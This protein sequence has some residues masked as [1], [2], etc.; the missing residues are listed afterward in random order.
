[1]RGLIWIVGLFLAA[2]GLA[3]LAAQNEGYVLLVMPPWRAE[4]SLNL[5][6]LVS[7]FGFIAS[8]LVIRAA[9]H[10]Y[11]LPSTVAAYRAR[12]KREKAQLALNTATA[13][14]FEGQYRQAL[15]NAKHAHEEGDAPALA[16]L[17]AAR[18]AYGLRDD[19]KV[20]HW[21]AEAADS[22]PSLAAARGMTELEFLCDSRQFGA[23][24]RVWETLPEDAR[25]QVKALRLA[26]RIYRAL[27]Q[28]QDMLKT[29]RLLE[30]QDAIAPEAALPFKAQA[31]GQMLAELASNAKDDGNTRTLVDY[32]G[33]IPKEERR[34]ARIA[35]AGVEAYLT[36]GD[37]TGARKLIEAQVDVE[38]SS[39]LAML[40]AECG[41]EESKIVRDRLALGEKWLK[42]HP[43][44]ARLLLTLGRLCQ[45]L[46]LWGKAR[47]YFEASLSVETTMAA[48]LALAA[49]L[50]QLEEAESAN[51]AYRK[52]VQLCPGAVALDKAK[53]RG[54]SE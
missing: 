1:M 2:S 6:L 9:V 35:L 11:R 8:Y 17:V 45:N 44:D 42:A 13:E 19:E 36:A 3:Y 7:L 30:R 20:Q 28:W 10:L 38:W 48:Q 33:S 15:K 46:Q 25:R 21:L 41:A 37:T 31:H 22:G 53:P 26:L 34:N 24:L 51:T 29:V 32:W 4:V 40:Y 23:A 12:R 16:A 39:E 43:K 52:A 49:L 18:A 47:S 14:L 27:E 50:D 54:R 5:F